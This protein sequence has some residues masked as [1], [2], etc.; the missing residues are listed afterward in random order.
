MRGRLGLPWS[1]SELR[2][3]IAHVADVFVV[4]EHRGRCISKLLMR[5]I[6]DTTIF[7]SRRVVLATR[8]C[9]WTYA[10]FGFQPLT[11]P[12]NFMSIHKPDACR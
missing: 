4:P 2:E 11:Q 6:V 3:T 10:Q 9:A 8:I 7:R 5:G 1:V 12:E